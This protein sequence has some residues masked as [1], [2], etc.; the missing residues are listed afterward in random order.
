M[1]CLMAPGNEITLV[2]ALLLDETVERATDFTFKTQLENCVS[3]AE[4]ADRGAMT[5]GAA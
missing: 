2:E 5:S 1:A 3:I 4:A